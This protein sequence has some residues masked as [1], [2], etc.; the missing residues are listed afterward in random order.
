MLPQQYKHDTS[1]EDLIWVSLIIPRRA[2]FFI[3]N[4]TPTATENTPTKEQNHIA[5]SRL[6]LLSERLAKHSIKKRNSRF[7]SSISTNLGP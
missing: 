1:Q 7:F 6:K 5:L 2:L 4:L 3:L